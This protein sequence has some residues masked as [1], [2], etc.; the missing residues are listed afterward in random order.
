[1]AE[2]S[3]QQIGYTKE[4]G[5]RVQPTRCA[6][7]NRDVRGK[8]HVEHAG[9][10][11]TFV[12]VLAQYDHLWPQAAPAYGFSVE[13]AANSDVEGFTLDAAK[14]EEIISPSGNNGAGIVLPVLI[15]VKKSRTQPSVIS[16]IPSEPNPKEGE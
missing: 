2:P 5:K 1:M 4:D 10:D 13:E 3:K 9:P 11:G 6:V 7:S 15:P 12:Y 8:P 16:P 14:E